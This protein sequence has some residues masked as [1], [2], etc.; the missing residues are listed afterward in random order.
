MP[1]WMHESR[2]V[3]LMTRKNP[4]GGWDNGAIIF[5]VLDTIF[6]VQPLLNPAAFYKTA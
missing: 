2:S 1:K 5:E 6:F 3:F 4:A